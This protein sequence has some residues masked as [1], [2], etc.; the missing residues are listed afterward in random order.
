MKRSIKKGTALILSMLLL[1]T[2]LTPAFAESAEHYDTVTGYPRLADVQQQLNAN[3]AIIPDEIT[4]HSDDDFDPED[5]SRMTGFDHA[6]VNIHLYK[7]ALSA[8]FKARIPGSYT[9]YYVVHPT[10]GHP[11]YETSRKVHVLESA[12][13]NST[14]GG[15][16]DNATE[17]TPDQT[18]DDTEDDPHEE[19]DEMDTV[20]SEER[21]DEEQPAEYSADTSEP[22]LYESGSAESEDTP[23]D[24]SPEGPA[25]E[26]DGQTEQAVKNDDGT[27]VQP[28]E[29]SA[30]EKVASDNSEAMAAE[31]ETSIP[32]EDGSEDEAGNES[33]DEPMPHDE[34]PVDANDLTEHPADENILNPLPTEGSEEKDEEAAESELPS[35]DSAGTDEL[36]EA[37]SGENTDLSISDE[38]NDGSSSESSS[39]E[40]LEESSIEDNVPTE[41]TTP[42]VEETVDYAVEI[43]EDI[44]TGGIVMSAAAMTAD[45]PV[46]SAMSAE[47]PD[48]GEQGMSVVLDRGTQVDYPADLGDWATTGYRVDGKVAYCLEAK[49]DGPKNGTYMAE[50]LATNPSLAKALYYGYGGPGDLSGD[51]YAEYDDDVRYVM[52]HIAACY[53]YTGDFETATV[54]CWRRGKE[55]YRIQEYIDY[56]DALPDPPSPSIRLTNDA[57]TIKA[58]EDGSQ[59]TTSTTLD[60]DSRNGITLTLPD[61]VTYHNQDT[62]ATQTGGTVYI[63]GGTTFFFSAPS[64]ESG[65][66]FSEQLNGLIDHVWQVIVFPTGEKSQDIGSYMTETYGDSVQFSVAWKNELRLTLI[67]ADASNP[68]LQ[69][70][71]AVIGIYSDEA[72]T[73]L[74]ATMT[75]GDDGTA[76]CSLTRDF[77]CVYLKELTAPAGYRLNKTVY[78]VDVPDEDSITA[79]IKDEK[80]EA[81]LKITKMGEALTGAIPTDNGLVFTYESRRL[82]GA[83]YRVIAN[84]SIYNMD[85]ALLYQKGDVVVENL[86][87]D[88]NGEVFI[89]GIPLGSYLIEETQAPQGYLLSAEKHE[90]TLDYAGQEAE[91]AYDETTFV[92]DRQKADVSIVKQDGESAAPLAGAVFGL[93]NDT[94]IY[95]M[96]GSLLAAADTLIERVTSGADGSAAFTADLPIGHSYTVREIQ[97]PSGYSLTNDAYSF[98]FSAVDQTT[99]VVTFS[100]TFTDNTLMTGF[101][102]VKVDAET[103]MPQGDAKLSGAVYGLY[104]RDAIAHPDGSTGALYEKDALV[105]TM[106]TDA[107]GYASADNLYPGRYYLKEITPSEGYMLDTAEYDIDFTPTGIDDQLGAVCT[108]SEQVM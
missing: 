38:H 73:N 1:L 59:V 13:V 102:F 94:A 76:S 64:S 48:S 62:G 16:D 52:T 14:E 86:I 27:A 75:T 26:S 98:T 70:S 45:E 37:A 39:P 12:V 105:L 7:N 19:K 55:K 3:E 44:S 67:K 71:G 95:S 66:W 42:T 83:V 65:V 92:N 50:V 91:V 34:S 74:I 81:G 104:A 5:T 36:T 32:I 58:V 72:C 22:V 106:T 89:S 100:H 88:E 15:T 28:A 87:T 79:M 90:V 108:V 85:G 33:S 93:Y 20:Q 69:L 63:A 78:T 8:E 99:P 57:L 30:T 51:F 96:S 46:F 56:L 60:A 61:N 103:G 68:N 101:K 47:S 41:E 6:S 29:E 80:Q 84:D 4:I 35:D 9:L 107:D 54:G 43:V 2:S 11:A 23:T 17:Q 77:A 10:S 18:D 40:A 24:V 53:F 31:D 21:L 49:K 25:A 82:S 97:A